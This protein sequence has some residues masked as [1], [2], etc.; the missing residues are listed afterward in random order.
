VKARSTRP[1]ATI[2]P[3]LNGPLASRTQTETGPHLNEGGSGSPHFNEGSGRGGSTF[4][5]GGGG[6]SGGGMFL[7]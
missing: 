7:G 5:E 6:D 4:E 2:N 1:H 3:Q